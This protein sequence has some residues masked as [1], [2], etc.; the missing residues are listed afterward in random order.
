[1]PKSEISNGEAK[2]LV[3]RWLRV[4]KDLTLAERVF[5]L[6]NMMTRTL[7]LQKIKKKED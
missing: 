5:V 1:M 4:D 2:K 6:E 3:E 7:L